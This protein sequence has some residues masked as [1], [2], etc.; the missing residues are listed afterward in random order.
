M[1]FTIVTVT[2][3]VSLPITSHLEVP[4]RRSI[5]ICGILFMIITLQ[6]DHR[7]LAKRVLALPSPYKRFKYI[8][9]CMQTSLAKSDLSFLVDTKVVNAPY[10]DIHV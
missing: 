1:L 9:D 5:K 6:R 10:Y 7:R 2:A 4:K 3:L 8:I